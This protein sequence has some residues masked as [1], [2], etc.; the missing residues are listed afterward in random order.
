MCS[1]G[2]TTPKRFID[3]RYLLDNEGI[4]EDL[5]NSFL[6][7]LISHNRPIAELLAPSPKDIR[8]SF[9]REFT[10]MTFDEVSLDDLYKV[11]QTNLWVK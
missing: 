8:K 3:I 4:T 7:Y 6:V 11:L 1:A 5:K 10:G 9:D 2:Q